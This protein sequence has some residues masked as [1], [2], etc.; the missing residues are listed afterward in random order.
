MNQ[1]FET[2]LTTYRAHWRADLINNQYHHIGGDHYNNI[3]RTTILNNTPEWYNTDL[4]DNSSYFQNETTILC[5]LFEANIPSITRYNSNNEITYDNI[6]NN[7]IIHD[8][9]LHTHFVIVTD[10]LNENTLI[11]HLNMIREHYRYDNVNEV[12]NNVRTKLLQHMNMD[13]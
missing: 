3:E 5:R 7:W 4:I 2:E 6:S 13:G 8:G 1:P 9:T 12:I 10:E 11:R